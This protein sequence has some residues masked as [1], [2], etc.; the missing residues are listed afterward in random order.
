MGSPLYAATWLVNV[1]TARGAELNAGH[2]ILT[3]SLTAAVAV[4]PGDTI[5]AAVDRLG[6]VTAVF[7]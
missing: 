2:V 6:S 4:Q 3:G 5:T 7:D 1:L